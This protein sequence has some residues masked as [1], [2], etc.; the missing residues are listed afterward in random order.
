MRTDKCPFCGESMVWQSD[1][2]LD[3][4]HPDFNLEGVS[5]F[6][7]CY[8]C[9]FMFDY[10]FVETENGIVLAMILPINENEEE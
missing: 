8:R 10:I 2:G 3:E 1:F 6:W 5:S 4:T 9:N 7:C